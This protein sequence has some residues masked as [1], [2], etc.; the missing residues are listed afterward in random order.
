M[1]RERRIDLPA[2]FEVVGWVD[3]DGSPVEDVED[4][5][6]SKFILK[7]CETDDTWICASPLGERG[8]AQMSLKN[9]LALGFTTVE[10][11]EMIRYE[12]LSENVMDFI[13]SE[14]E[15]NAILHGPAHG[16]TDTVG[17]VR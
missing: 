8:I 3:D 1:A 17:W 6:K 15:L 16:A 4:R 13:R 2:L 7:D 12:A 5:F 11:Q 14:D 10:Y 9:V